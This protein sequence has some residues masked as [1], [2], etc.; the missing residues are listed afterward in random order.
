MVSPQRHQ[1][2]PDPTGHT[3]P[4]DHPGH[5]T[6][7]AA[8]PDTRPSQQARHHP[9]SR[10]LRRGARPP[11]QRA[12]SPLTVSRAA[13]TQSRTPPRLACSPRITAS[14]AARRAVARR[15][16]ARP[17]QGRRGD[18]RRHRAA[19]GCCWWR[20]W[21]GASRR[22]SRREY[23]LYELHL[24]THDQAKP[25]DL[26]DM[27]ESIANIVRAWPAE[28][29]R[30][31][32]PYRRARADLRPTPATAG[33]PR[34]GV[35]D[36]HPLRAARRRRAGRRDQR[37]LPRRPARPRPRRASPAR[38]PG[39]LREPGYVMRFRKERSFVYS[40]IAD[41]ERA[42]ILAA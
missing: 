37:R 42:R 9:C 16:R 29:M 11:P 8:N 13:V 34:D 12:R 41:G 22:R 23:A 6:A 17:D 40:L 7:T 36:Q 25:Q 4:A 15:D 33:R 18:R 19:S 35:V 5:R 28:R 21:C 27:V 20:S 3:D 10:S 39:A 38:G 2:R 26:E 30:D 14:G 24:S 1:R 31:G 32:Q